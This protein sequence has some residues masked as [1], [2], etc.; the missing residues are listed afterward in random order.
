MGAALL[1]TTLT[2]SSTQDLDPAD[3]AA[4]SLGLQVRGLVDD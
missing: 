2:A 4:V 1:V 3:A